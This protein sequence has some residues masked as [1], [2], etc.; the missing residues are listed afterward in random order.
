MRCRIFICWLLL[1]TASVASA[2][3][4]YV[5]NAAAGL[6]NG[7]SWANAW[8]NL[9]NVNGISPGD[10][11]YISG[12]STRKTYV[13]WDGS[14]SEWVPANGGNGAAGN[15]ITYRVGQDAGHNGVVV[16][17]GSGTGP[18]WGRIKVERWRHGT[19]SGDYQG[20][21]NLVV[22]NAGGLYGDF[23][24]DVTIDHVTYYSQIRFNGSTNIEIS[25]CFLKPPAPVD[26]VITW[27]VYPPSEALVSYTNNIIRNC[28]IVMPVSDITPAWGS[29]GIAGG[30]C[31]SVF[32]NL[33]TVYYVTNNTE[34]QHT[35]GCQNLGGS[36]CK[37]FANTF[38]NISNYAIYWECFASASNV[39]IYNNVFR[40]NSTFAHANTFNLGVAVGPQGVSG[41][42]F[43][44]FVV[45]NNTFMDFFGRSAIAFGQ[46]FTTNTY[47]NCVLANNLMVNSGNAN[48]AAFVVSDGN[49]TNGISIFNNKAIAG[50]RGGTIIAPSQLA[51]PGGSTT[52]QF[53]SYSE[54]SP[55]NNARLLPNDTAAI[56]AGYDLSA[57]FTTDSDGNTRSGTWDLGAY[58]YIAPATTYRGF[59]FGPGVKLIGPWRVTQ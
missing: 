55:N 24:S 17:D 39:W 8:T 47:V 50:V 14:Y 19:I 9:A 37:L 7:T 41:K 5:D 25:Y 38:E 10:T 36:N 29:D 42:V 48:S 11:V 2:T 20:K 45:A 13:L 16:F 6:R 59:S 56:N 33:F 53:V 58:E 30:R 22:T 51:Y 32:S 44:N 18:G 35:D 23:A 26:P 43:S 57:Y 52:V 46:N 54:L 12:G 1:H 21:N 4:W 31:S 28:T 27:N 40:H 3:L 15:R 34:W 49:G